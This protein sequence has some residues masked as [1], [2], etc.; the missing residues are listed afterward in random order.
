MPTT[1]DSLDMQQ[2]QFNK[3]C[4]GQKIVKIKSMTPQAA[5]EQ[6]LYERPAILVL[7]NGTEIYALSDPE[8]NGV[9]ALVVG[10]FLLPPKRMDNK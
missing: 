8:G 2:Q 3:A 6:G 4:L 1:R 10:D 5:D 9:G 7:E